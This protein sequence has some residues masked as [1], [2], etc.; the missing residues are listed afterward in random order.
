M[1]GNKGL[2]NRGSVTIPSYSQQ[3]NRR[4]SRRSLDFVFRTIIDAL[5][6]EPVASHEARV[7]GERMW[8][9][10]SPLCTAPHIILHV[11]RSCGFYVVSL[12]RRHHDHHD[13]RDHGD[14]RARPARGILQ[15]A[16]PDFRILAGRPNAS[17][18]VVPRPPS[19]RNAIV[20]RL[21]RGRGSI[22]SAV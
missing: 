18:Y 1:K 8:P 6:G 12:A 15:V 20:C 4:I 17:S 2:D 7:V 21:K 10:G 13:H 22:T 14:R 3:Y 19:T 16:P 9:A 5:G 11:E